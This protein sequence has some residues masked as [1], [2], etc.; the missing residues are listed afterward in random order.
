MSHPYF[1]GLISGTSA[2]GIDAALVSFQDKQPELI[3][4]HLE[5]FPPD[6]RERLTSLFVPGPDQIDLLGELD[7]ELGELFAAAANHLLQKAGVNASRISAIG[8]HGQTVR[9]RPL[10]KHPF[11][12]QIADPNTIAELTGIPV[13]ADFRRRD[14]IAGGQGAPLAPAFHRA[15]LHSPEENRVIVN[16]GGI[17][18]ITCLPANDN[19][20]LMAMDTGPANGLMDAWALKHLGREYDE[21][22]AWACS[23]NVIQSLLKNWLSDPYFS[24][25][26]PKSTG[27]EYFHLEWARMAGE[28][29]QFSAADVQASFLSLSI[30][31]ISDAIKQLPCTIDRV[32]ACGGGV[33]NRALMTGL[34]NTL[35]CPVES[36]GQY[37]VEADWVEAM[38][39]AWLASKHLEKIKVELSPFT[40][41]R[42][43][44]LLGGYYPAG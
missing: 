20:G 27:K 1:I 18:N 43:A 9:H 40:G 31:T 4:S 34:Q 26:A 17:A 41:S 21:N 32:L 11:T 16:L 44:V 22:G 13:V 37:G 10:N 7:I 39:F 8:S 36:T 42:R 28:L 23:G 14:M 12:L 35:D 2:D 24:L 3:C 29:D 25:P 33:R 19:N 38:T 30:T 6:T 15:V 5:R